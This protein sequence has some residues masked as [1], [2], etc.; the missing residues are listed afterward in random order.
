MKAT[1][2]PG[3]HRPTQSCL[4]HLW[5]LPSRKSNAPRPICQQRYDEMDPNV[6]AKINHAFQGIVC[7]FS[8]CDLGFPGRRGAL[9]LVNNMQSNF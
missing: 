6:I 3:Q 4:R 7:L 5:L 1:L 2:G 9:L 8:R